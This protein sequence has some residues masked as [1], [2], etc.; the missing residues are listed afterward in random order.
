[1]GIRLTSKFER[2]MV[3]AVLLGYVILSVEL[4]R[5]RPPNS[6]EGEHGSVAAIFEAHHYLAMP[7]AN[8][9]WLPGLDRH[10]YAIMP[11]YFVVLSAWFR[12]FGIALITMRF[13][14]VLWGVI[15]LA[16]WYTIVRLLSGDRLIS[17]LSLVLIA[18]NYD[19]IDLTSGRYD[20]MCAALNVAGLA[21]YLALRGRRLDL[22]LFLSNLLIA[23]A[24]MTHPYGLFGFAA[25]ALFAISLDRDRIGVKQLALSAL[26]YLVALSAWG[27]YIAQDVAVFRAQF[28]ANAATR[29]PRMNPLATLLAE[30]KQR[31]VIQVAG[32]R[33]HVPVYMKVKV[34]ILAAILFSIIGCLLLRDIRHN[35]NYKLLLILTALWFL[36]LTYLEPLKMYGY[37]VHIWPLYFVLV[38]IFLGTMIKRGGLLRYL[39][40][41][42]V[43]MLALFAPVSVAYRV[44]LNSY[45]KAFLP[46]MAFL[47]QHVHGTALVVA[48]GEFG[49][50]LGFAR[51]VL[52]D[53]QLGC[54]NGKTPKYIVIDKEYEDLIQ[55][56]KANNPVIY[57]QIGKLLSRQY[58]V[59]FESRSGYDFYRIYARAPQT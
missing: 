36:M 7:M 19:Y 47:Q 57:A 52:D 1:M 44:R 13:F 25:L 35:R 12:A 3:C 24:F 15:A 21:I 30:L 45:Q 2:L 58:K 17:L 16:S 6:D 14:S 55:K 54:E 56:L 8:E 46:A 27:L 51:H 10:L 42:C 4:A 9:V 33:P 48:P 34:L 38:A 50:G 20:I 18:F 59:V 39:A 31:Y 26:P 53:P 49:F 22:A 29:L 40:T 5:V 41:A 32:W 11:L 43:V 37:T 28:F 23:A